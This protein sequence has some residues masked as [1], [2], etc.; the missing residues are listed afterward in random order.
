MTEDFKIFREQVHIQDVATRL[1]GE[2]IRGMYKYPGERTAS[3]KIYPETQSFYDFGRNC[4][5]DVIALAQYLRQ[6]KKEI[7]VKLDEAIKTFE[8]WR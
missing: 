3:L 1:L 5:G 6:C 7:A 4:G 8:N 2:P